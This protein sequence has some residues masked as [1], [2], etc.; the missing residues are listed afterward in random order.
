MPQQKPAFGS[1]LV[2]GK[3]GFGAQLA[4]WLLGAGTCAEVLFLDDAAPGAAGPLRGYTDPA[5]QSRCT[6]AFVGLGNNALRV[7]LLRGLAAAGYRTPVFVHPAAVVSPSAD[8]GPGCIVGP[9][10][11]VGS[12][13][14]AGTGCIVNAGAI[15]DHDAS[16]GN[17]VH[18]APGAIVK[19]G[20][21]VEDFA[22]I[23]SG[24]VVFPPQE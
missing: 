14:K 4:E 24:E 5:L 23:E 6:A 18:I 3:G 8:L 17:G 19:A 7:E 20:A 15:V 1:V 9:L 2:L 13:A 21:A 22:K 16:L 12:G 11:F 10:A